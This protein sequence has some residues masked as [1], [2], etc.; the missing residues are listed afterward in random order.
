MGELGKITAFGPVT[1]GANGVG[2]SAP[3]PALAM[4]L[5]V[6]AA[7]ESVLGELNFVEGHLKS[8]LCTLETVRGITDTRERL[9]GLQVATF[10][11][12]EL[13]HFASNADAEMVELCAAVRREPGRQQ[14]PAQ[15]DAY[16]FA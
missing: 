11:S 5:D 13:E 16:A 2:H 12:A 10:A 9:K 14:E 3:E 7:I 4:P 6:C 8:L 1:N 15:E